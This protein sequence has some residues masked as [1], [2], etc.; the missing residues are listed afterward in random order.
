[1]SHNGTL[2]H[3]GI[4]GQKWGVRRFQNADGSLTSAGRKRYDDSNDLERTKSECLTREQKA[5]RNKRIRTAAIITGAAALTTVAAIVAVKKYKQLSLTNITKHLNDKLGND[6]TSVI[7][8]GRTFA[9]SNIASQSALDKLQSK[10][11]KEAAEIRRYKNVMD[12]RDK[13]PSAIR[14]ASQKSPFEQWKTQASV[15]GNSNPGRA[16]SVLTDDAMRQNALNKEAAHK[17]LDQ[18]K[19]DR[20]RS[21]ERDEYEK[22]ISDLEKRLAEARA[23]AAEREERWKRQAKTH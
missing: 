15:A 11:D 8:R 9:E 18:N 22:H 2:C 17:M 21:A 13:D 23:K 5:I 19:I 1:M 3:H 7:N 16:R 4:K 20:R 6:L 14:L 10:A 12:K